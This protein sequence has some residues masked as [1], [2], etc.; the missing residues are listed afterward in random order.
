L[1][2]RDDTRAT[3]DNTYG[4]FDDAPLRN[5]V[6]DYG[7]ELYGADRSLERDENSSLFEIAPQ[8]YG[9]STIMKSRN[10]KQ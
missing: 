4:E 7:A 9:S 1:A 10:Q 8:D 3:L 6:P 5:S 2:L